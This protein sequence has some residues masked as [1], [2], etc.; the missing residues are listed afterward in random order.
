LEEFTDLEVI[1]GHGADQRHQ[2]LANISGDGF[3]I[4][5]KGEVIAALGGVFVEGTLEEV[6]G[7][8]DLALKLFP[9]E[10]EDLV[11]FAH[12]YAY[13]YAYFRACKSARQ[14]VNFRNR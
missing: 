4:D 7:V 2:F 14:G 5:L 13:L 8:I 9:T 1:S 6:E 12:K 3:L 10:L 11:L